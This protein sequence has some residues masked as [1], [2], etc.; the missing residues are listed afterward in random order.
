MC[1][2]S[3]CRIFCPQFIAL[4]CIAVAERD[5]KK[6]ERCYLEPRAQESEHAEDCD[7]RKDH[8]AVDIIVYRQTAGKTEIAV[9]PG[10]NPM[11]AS[12]IRCPK[13]DSCDAFEGM[14]MTD[15][16]KGKRCKSSLDKS[17]TEAISKIIKDSDMA[18]QIRKKIRDSQ[19]T[20][21]HHWHNDETGDKGAVPS[22]IHTADV[23]EID[24]PEV[25]DLMWLNC[26][27]AIDENTE[28]QADLY[29][30]VAEEI[31]CMPPLPG[32]ENFSAG[33]NFLLTF[34]AYLLVHLDRSM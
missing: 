33:P 15:T 13:D 18:L 2:L 21:T 19:K 28:G 9:L 25:E 23:S 16:P 26:T 11:G 29:K 5:L 14:H 8:E 24:F 27:Q 30:P 4:V 31:G 32:S 7:F 20:A 10:R 12:F 1:I 6:S 17:I 22:H 3:G 34:S